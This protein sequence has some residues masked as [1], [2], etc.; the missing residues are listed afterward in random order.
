MSRKRSKPAQPRNCDFLAR[1]KQLAWERAKL[2]EK[3]I[4]PDAMVQRPMLALIAAAEAPG[5]LLRPSESPWL[6]AWLCL[7]LEK[8]GGSGFVFDTRY[9]VGA[10]P[11]SGRL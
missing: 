11:L 10:L 4:G 5:G 1:G 6:R 8:R 9:A 2:I 3:S 7:L